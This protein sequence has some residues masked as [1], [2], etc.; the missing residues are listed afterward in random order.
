MGLH[1][2][3]DVVGTVH[4]VSFTGDFDLGTVPTISDAL[5]RAI[6]G[7]ESIVAVDLDGVSTPDDTAL[8]V[9]VAAVAHA[10]DAGRR[11][12]FVCS[13]PVVS[14]R[15]DRFSLPHVGRLVDVEG[16]DEMGRP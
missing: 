14:R 7:S 8:G 15:L 11:M 3:H 16:D 10:R 2:R 9:L 4:S 6:A 13:D 1:A 5:H 12:V